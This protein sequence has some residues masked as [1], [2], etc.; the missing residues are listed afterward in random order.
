MDQ[1][2][3]LIREFSEIPEV[4]SIALGGSRASKRNDENS[5]YDL[6]C[7]VTEEISPDV[8]KN[9]LQKY[10]NYMEINNQYWE[11]EDDCTLNNGIVIEIIYRSITELNEM[12]KNVVEK[13]NA[14]NGYTTCMWDNLLHCEILYDRG[15]NLQDMKKAYS[16]PYPDK[17]RDNIINKNLELLDGY[18]PSYTK[19][20]E[21]ALERDDIISVN[22]RITEFLA[23]YFDIIFAVNRKTHPGEK[24]LIKLC[25]DQC[26]LLP[27][28]FEEN[29]RELLTV[30]QSK[31]QMMNTMDKIIMNLKKLIKDN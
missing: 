17:L 25:K 31:D 26:E 11:T 19:Q 3:E 12:I 4:E 27:I 13:A 24:R 16:I 1:I 10:C 22:H 5:D 30:N 15:H 7:Y 21:K 2:K 28:D 18:I 8:R 20:I 29:L 9:I 14:N 6:Y 23:S